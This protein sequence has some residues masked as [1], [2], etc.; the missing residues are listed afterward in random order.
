MPTC[1]W[2]TE[3]VPNKIISKKIK[4]SKL[5]YNAI[6]EKNKKY[7]SEKIIIEERFLKKK[8]K[9]K[10][11]YS[12]KW[13]GGISFFFFFFFFKIT[14]IWGLRTDKIWYAIQTPYLTQLAKHSH[15]YW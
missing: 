5:W 12:K 9:K 2:C 6:F 1:I 7:I 15:L 14:R 10:R 8:K 4:I 13:S 11:S 3:I